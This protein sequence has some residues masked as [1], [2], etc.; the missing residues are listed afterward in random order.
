MR[1][2]AITLEYDGSLFHGWQSQV[3]AKTVQD[4]VSGALCSLDGKPVRLA[5]ASRTDAGVHA[6]GQVATF[7]TE[8]KIPADKYAYALNT[9]LPEGISCINSYEAPDD[10][11]ARFSAKSKVYSY[12]ILNRRHPSALYRNY[13]WHVPLPLDAAAMRGAARLF[14][15]SHDFR[16]FMSTGSPVKS[17]VRNIYSLD[18]DICP[19]GR[20][21]QVFRTS[22][23]LTGDEQH[24]YHSDGHLTA[25]VPHINFSDKQLT[26]DEQ[27]GAFILLLIDGDGFLYNMV[28]IITGTLVYIGQGKLDAGDI[29][30]ALDTGMRGYAGKTAPPQGLCLERVNYDHFNPISL[31]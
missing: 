17:T 9:V 5:G 14:I 6:R 24:N 27:Q 31:Y 21:P 19:H 16:A 10:F 29:R 11:H 25:T 23:H 20:P 18:L 28:R 12:M 8:S 4:A 7:F 13:A 1:N 22:G 15:G 30:H 3:N 26:G 2:I